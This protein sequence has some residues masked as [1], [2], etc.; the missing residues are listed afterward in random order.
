MAFHFNYETLSL[1]FIIT[2][3][4]RVNF[5][6]FLFIVFCQINSE[7]GKSRSLTFVVV[8]FLLRLLWYCCGGDL[9]LSNRVV[10]LSLLCFN[11]MVL[12]LL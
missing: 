4:T 11:V 2:C 9:M 5:Y 10:L 3:F 12:L 1:S 7:S 8:L 6:L